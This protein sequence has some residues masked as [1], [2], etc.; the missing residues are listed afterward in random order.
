[1]SMELWLI[2]KILRSVWVT[3]IWKKSDREDPSD[4][5]PISITN[6]ILKVIERVI[7]KQMA[8]YL[9]DKI[10]DDQHGA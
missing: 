8:D 7:R 6:Y 3:P 9:G 5:R 1:M 2:P 4:Y 10:T